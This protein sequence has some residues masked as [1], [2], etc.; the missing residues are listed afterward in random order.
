MDKDVKKYRLF[1]LLSSLNKVERSSFLRFL[2]S[3]YHNQRQDVV[4]LYEKIRPFLDDNRPLLSLELWKAVYKDK[5]F[6]EQKLRL[7]MSY[8]TKLFETFI[9]IEMSQSDQFVKKMSVAQH[10]AQASA[11]KLQEKWLKDAHKALEKTKHRQAEYLFRS[12]E[13]HLEMA[14]LSSAYKP[15]QSPD[16]PIVEHYFEQAVLAMKMRQKVWSLNLKQVYQ[17]EQRTVNLLDQFAQQLTLE[18]IGDEAAVRVYWYAA[19]FMEHPD[20]DDFFYEFKRLLLEKSALFPHEEAREL[21]LL[22]INHGVRKLNQGIKSYFT[23]VMDLYKQGLQEN[24]LLTNGV[25][26]RFTYHNIVAAALQIN[27]VDWAKK[28]LEDWT[29]KLERRF[30][31]R[32]YNF[33][34]AKIAY[35]IHNFDEALSRLQQSNYHDP[36]LNLGARTLLL[37]I[38]FE[39]G[40]WDALYS[41]LDAFQSYLRRKTKLNYHRKNYQNLIRFTKKILNTNLRDKVAKEQLKTQIE[42]TP[43]LTEKHWLLERL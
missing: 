24:Y 3:P 7:L 19:K 4:L 39:Q 12:Y 25:L 10:L 38:Y 37:K 1:E 31:E 16:F 42:T 34:Q 33:N 27:E 11:Y 5:T 14:R 13:Y 18:D 21:Y 20:E 36:L 6:D 2:N 9:Q 40:E 35:S 23:D 28:F 17:Q 15:H 32:M 26:S 41:H 30:R 22:A 43:L 29:P 8:L